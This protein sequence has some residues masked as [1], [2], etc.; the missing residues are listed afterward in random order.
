MKKIIVFIG[1]ALISVTGFCQQYS[2]KKAFFSGQQVKIKGQVK[3]SD[4]IIS[5][6]TERQFSKFDVIKT[7]DVPNFKAF[8]A[9][10]IGP[11]SSMRSSLN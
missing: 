1:F 8:K 9:K 10:N 4:S 2:F 6:R 5:I 7:T 11:D 3:I